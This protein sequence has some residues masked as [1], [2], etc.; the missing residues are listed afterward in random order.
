MTTQFIFKL[1]CG[2]FAQLA[3]DLI[4][5]YGNDLFDLAVGFGEFEDETDA[6]KDYDGIH[7]TVDDFVVFEAR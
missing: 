6:E 7:D 5:R 2:C 4:S 3:S 1:D